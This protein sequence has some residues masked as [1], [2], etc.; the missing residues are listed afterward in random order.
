MQVVVVVLGKVVLHV[1]AGAVGVVHVHDVWLAVLWMV[2]EDGGEVGVQRVRQRV[3]QWMR[4]RMRQWVG[5]QCPGGGHGHGHGDRASCLSLCRGDR[6]SIG[7]V[8]DGSM[9]RLGF[10]A[11][12]SSSLVIL[13]TLSFTPS[14]PFSL[15]S[16]SLDS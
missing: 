8:F 3:R 12:S 5:R 16:C 9:W 15:S 14:P 2:V 11:S 7:F 1:G 13:S 4:Q 10:T 6:A